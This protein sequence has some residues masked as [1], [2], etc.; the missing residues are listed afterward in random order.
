MHFYLVNLLNDYYDVNN[1]NILDEYSNFFSDKINIDYPKEKDVFF[2]KVVNC[3]KIIQRMWR[4]RKI[5]KHLE[6]S[7]KNE[8]EELK[9]MLIYK[10]LFYYK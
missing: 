3:T 2:D 1:R 4:K 8:D 10:N 6:L 9:K 5:K 7:D